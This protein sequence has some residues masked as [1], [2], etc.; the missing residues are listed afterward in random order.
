MGIAMVVAV[1]VMTLAIAQG[2]RGDAG[3][4]RLA[5]ERDPAAQGRDRRKRSARVLRPQLPLI[6]A[7]PQVARGADG[8]PLASPELVVIIALPRQSGQPAGQRAGARRRA[9]APSRSAT[10]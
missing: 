3:G 10:R 7:L 8:H 9:A 1:F 6:E 2:F 4:E 5:R